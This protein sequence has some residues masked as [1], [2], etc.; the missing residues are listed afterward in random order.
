MT[1][2]LDRKQKPLSRTTTSAVATDIC[3]RRATTPPS[4]ASHGPSEQRQLRSPA[5]VRA[6]TGHRDLLNR[7]FAA[8]P[9]LRHRQKIA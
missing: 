3:V 7:H 2:P 6:R 9:S 1:S 4:I 8:T 5:R